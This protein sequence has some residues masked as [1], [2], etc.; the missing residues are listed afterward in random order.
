MARTGVRYLK[1]REPNSK[2]MLG[3]KP[4]HATFRKHEFVLIVPSHGNVNAAI[5]RR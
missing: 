1:E 5:V 4:W 3:C 2:V